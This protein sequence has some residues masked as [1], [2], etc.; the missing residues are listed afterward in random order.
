[1]SFGLRLWRIGA[2]FQILEILMYSSGMKLGPAARVSAKPL[3]EDGNLSQNP[4]FEM[5]STLK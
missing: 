4:I 1:M 5:A 3:G 2:S